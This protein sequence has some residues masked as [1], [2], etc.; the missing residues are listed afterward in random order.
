MQ[1][2][3]MTTVQTMQN[4]LAAVPVHRGPIIP[5]IPVQRVP[6]ASG[7]PVGNVMGTEKWNALSA[8]AAE[9]NGTMV[10]FPIIRAIPKLL[11]GPGTDVSGAE[12]QEM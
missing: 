9:V 2:M 11:T 6:A 1:L 8:A 10:P 7:L 3:N 5:P 4:A 12:V